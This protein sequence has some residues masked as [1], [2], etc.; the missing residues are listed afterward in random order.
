MQ[1]K[2]K[3]WKKTIKTVKRLAKQQ[4][5]FFHLAALME[6]AGEVAKDLMDKDYDHAQEECVDCFVCV[7]ALYSKL[8]GK[9]KNFYKWFKKAVD[10]WENSVNGI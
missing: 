8:E 1:K 5:V 7:L 3:N 4:E 10:K 2:T 9:P 6:E